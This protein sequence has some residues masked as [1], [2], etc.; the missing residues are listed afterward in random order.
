MKINIKM[1]FMKKLFFVILTFLMSTGYVQASSYIFIGAGPLTE[2]GYLVSGAISKTVNNTIKKF[3]L[4]ASVESTQGDQET[5]RL[6]ESGSVE[7]GVVHSKTHVSKNHVRA[8]FSIP[9]TSFIVV[10]SE[11]TPDTVV[12]SFTKSI[13]ENL[14]FLKIKLESMNIIHP[15]ASESLVGGGLADGAVFTKG[16]MLTGFSYEL[17]PAAS[18]YYKEARINPER[19]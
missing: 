14:N 8:V 3:H 18:K 17:H 1:E 10:T 7:F 19:W 12:Y 2:K 11:K 9:Q 4:R 6:L 16:N 5:L 15:S 13:F